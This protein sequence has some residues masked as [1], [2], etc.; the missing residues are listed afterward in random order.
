M[1][2]P[3]PPSWMVIEL[4]MVLVVSPWPSVME[5]DVEGGDILTLGVGVVAIGADVVTGAT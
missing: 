2:A 4:G 1:R 3:S 5:A